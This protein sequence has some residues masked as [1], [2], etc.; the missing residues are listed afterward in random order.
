MKPIRV[1]GAAL[2]GCVILG[3]AAVA[4]SET[5]PS[6]IVARFP[7]GA[8]PADAL[9]MPCN[10]TSVAGAGSVWYRVRPRHEEPLGIRLVSYPAHLEK[11]EFQVY[12]DSP[13]GNGE[14]NL[15]GTG[16]AG[17]SQVF[18]EWIGTAEEGAA[19]YVNIVNNSPLRLDY[20]LCDPYQ[21]MVPF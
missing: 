19:Y 1:L 13:E 2:I 16:R 14:P 5:S 3:L 8:S 4:H 11:I 18:K 21:R 10:W 7:S 9:D 6:S 12:V 17:D 20:G 15:I